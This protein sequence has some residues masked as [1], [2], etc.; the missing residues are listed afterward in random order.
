[1][2]YSPAN[3]STNESQNGRKQF[4]L[5]VVC[6]AAAQDKQWSNEQ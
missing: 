2:Y 3:K 4:L 5:I 1:M 6:I